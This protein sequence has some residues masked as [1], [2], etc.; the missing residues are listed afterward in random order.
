VTI[1]LQV[2]LYSKANRVTAL[3]GNVPFSL[4][5]FYLFF[6]KKKKKEEKEK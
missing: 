5:F 4:F 1:V 3:W 6:F 2:N